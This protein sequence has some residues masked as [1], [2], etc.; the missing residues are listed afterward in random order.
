MDFV[1][2][3]TDAARQAAMAARQPYGPARRSALDLLRESP[4]TND[5]RDY[6]PTLERRLDN[7]LAL[8]WDWWTNH[9]APLRARWQHWLA[10]P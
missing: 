4:K 2:F 1:R 7:A 5:T 8:D 3:A 6:L 10:A 9:G